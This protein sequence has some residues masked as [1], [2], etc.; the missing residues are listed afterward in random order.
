MEADGHSLSKGLVYTSFQTLQDGNVPRRADLVDSECDVRVSLLTFSVLL[1][2]PP[3]RRGP[4][5]EA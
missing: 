2:A 4:M 1:R 5:R 3:H